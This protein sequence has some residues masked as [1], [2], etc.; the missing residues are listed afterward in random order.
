MDFPFEVK[1]VSNQ[2]MPLQK[3]G[4]CWL[5]LFLLS[6]RAVIL[7]KTGNPQVLGVSEGSI[8]PFK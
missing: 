1:G 3:C 4:D 2:V 6:F 8:K 7:S 5:S